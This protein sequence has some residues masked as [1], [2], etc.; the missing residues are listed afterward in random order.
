MKDKVLPKPL[1]AKEKTT[2]NRKVKRIT[3]SNPINS[4]GSFKVRM[5]STTMT[6]NKVKAKRSG[7]EIV[8]LNAKAEIKGMVKI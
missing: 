3:R 2:K 8:G 7:R 6:I 4:K 1:I 5:V